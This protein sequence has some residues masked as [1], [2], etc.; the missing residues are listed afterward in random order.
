M[1]TT[2]ATRHRRPPTP[3]APDEPPAVELDPHELP[4][5]HAVFAAATARPTP[6]HRQV[7]QALRSGDPSRLV[8]CRA[9]PPVDESDGLLTLLSLQDLA[10][11]P[12]HRLGSRAAFHG[13]PSVADLQH[14]LQIAYLERLRRRSATT[15][16]ALPDGV[17]GVRRAAALDRVPAVYKWL[18]DEADWDQMVAFLAVEGGPDAGFDDLV[19]LAQIG[20]GGVP[21]VALAQ[22]YWDEMG[23]G[24]PE[25]VHT[26][27]HH[28]LVD[29]VEMPR[30]ARADLPAPA[31]DRMALNG[32]LA[33]NRWLQPE[34]IGALG[35]LEL[36][37]GPRC[38]AVV[39]ALERLGAGEDAL[40]F[41]REHAEVDPVHGKDWLD[42][43]VEPLS[44]DPSWA[45]RMVD[46]A[47]WRHVVNDRFFAWW[48]GRQRCGTAAM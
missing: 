41:Y 15:R 22:N 24:R 18:R 4:T 31:L 36:Q 25:R 47:V 46:G 6:L 20:I 19:A 33:T 44:E 8:S 27:L 17:A 37:A 42:R 26:E 43:V 11:A 14:R 5:E 1:F 9:V 45:R 13:H 48:D 38:R 32:V 39:G 16:L 40:D 23:G 2:A 21:K 3:F 30:V 29:A 28:R 35:V 7:D 34:L 12:L 10:L